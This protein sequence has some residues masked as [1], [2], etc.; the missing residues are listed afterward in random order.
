[1]RKLT[2]WLVVGGAI[3]VIV[4]AIMIARVV[5]MAERL[6]SP[7]THSR[8]VAPMAMQRMKGLVELH[9]LRYGE[10]PSELSDMRFLSDFDRGSMTWLQYLPALDRSAYYLGYRGDI[11]GIESLGLPPDYWEG[12][13]Y[14]SMVALDGS[15]E[16]RSAET[17]AADVG[18]PRSAAE[19]FSDIY[20][21]SMNMVVGQL[22]LYMLRF[23]GYPETL[24]DLPDIP[25]FEPSI[26]LVE[27][28]PAGDGMSYIVRIRKT[29][30]GRG[31]LDLPGEYWTGTGFAGP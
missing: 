8:I 13:G 12:T 3:L 21:A 29:P 4:I 28:D 19:G 24:E 15:E 23:G 25:R 11:D 7:E 18:G 20:L 9:A 5:R 30:F 1:M 2:I 14:D 16:L 10:Y 6:S 17:V 31:D 27:Y 22:E 26:S